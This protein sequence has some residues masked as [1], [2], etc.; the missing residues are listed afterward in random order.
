MVTLQIVKYFSWLQ[1]LQTNSLGEV[2]SFENLVS[3][4]FEFVHALVETPRFRS[5]VRD[6]ISQVIY[7]VILFMQI[8]E[9]QISTW[10]SNPNRFVEDESED[11]FSYSVRISAQDLL[12]V[13][14]YFEHLRHTLFTFLLTFQALRQ[15]FEDEACAGLCEAV[16]RHLHEAD[17]AHTTGTSENWWKN[18]EASLLALGAMKDLLASQQ[19]QNQLPLDIVSI[20]QTSVDQ[21]NR[22]AGK[23]L[24]SHIFL[25]LAF[26]QLFCSISISAWSMSVGC[27]QIRKFNATCAS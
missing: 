27:E 13:F 2:I 3:S 1:C 10:T 21:H 18:V 5:S 24:A 11:S 16:T 23:H 17:Q 20:L 6:G 9:E 22:M 8:T 12:L 7:Y 4:I 19:K 26:K 14:P 25:L 15:E